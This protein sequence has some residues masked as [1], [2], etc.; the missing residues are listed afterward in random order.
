MCPL[1]PSFAGDLSLSPA[2]PCLLTPPLDPPIASPQIARLRAELERTARE[3]AERQGDLQRRHDA[4]LEE[5]AAAAAAALRRREEA[6]QSEQAELEARARG[7]QMRVNWA[8]R[9]ARALWERRFDE[10]SARH[11][12]LQGRFAARESRA[13]DL[14][15]IAELVR[16]ARGSGGRE[17]SV[18]LPPPRSPAPATPGAHVRGLPVRVSAG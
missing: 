18:H 7:R 16:E 1:P 9:V 2:P 6:S 14:R 8:F 13:E 5:R 15:R 17:G 4:V 12:E 11:R 10:L 3:A